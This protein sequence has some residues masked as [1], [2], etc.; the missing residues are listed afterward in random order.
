MLGLW[1]AEGCPL[2]S[3]ELKQSTTHNW[4]MSDWLG[5]FSSGKFKKKFIENIQVKYQNLG[6]MFTWSFYT[7]LCLLRNSH[8]HF[9]FAAG[10]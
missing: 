5:I 3:L 10:L 2:Y 6:Y 9:I 4:V 1:G 7:K 8:D